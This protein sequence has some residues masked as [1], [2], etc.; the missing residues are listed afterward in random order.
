M[1]R[2]RKLQ[3]LNFVCWIGDI[4]SSMIL[5]LESTRANQG[6][7]MVTTKFF[8]TTIQLCPMR[9][10]AMIT[11][12]TK[13][14][15]LLKQEKNAGQDNWFCK[16]LI[17]DWVHWNTLV[18]ALQDCA[19]QF[20]LGFRIIRH[21]AKSKLSKSHLSSSSTINCLIYRH[22]WALTGFF[23]RKTAN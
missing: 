16:E 8:S 9:L 1:W 4:N 19:S 14:T 7:K 12:T 21:S 3:L 23:P 11:I 6:T 5:S 20:L 18:E 17:E 15:F 13:Q 10:Q 22:R 2:Y